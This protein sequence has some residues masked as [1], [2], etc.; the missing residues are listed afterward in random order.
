VSKRTRLLLLVF[1]IAIGV[2]I[3]GIVVRG[4]YGIAV[5]ILNRSDST[6]YSV[7]AI[8]KPKPGTTYVGDLKANERKLLFI[9]PQGESHIELQFT[10]MTGA[11]HSQI[12]AGYVEKGYCGTARAEVYPRYVI[13]AHEDIGIVWCPGGW[14][15]FL[16]AAY[17]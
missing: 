6:L 14:F 8:A 16:R 9:Q 5:V 7:R 13:S 12:I 15:S 2:Y 3:V 17:E 1:I 10:D 4:Y 11:A